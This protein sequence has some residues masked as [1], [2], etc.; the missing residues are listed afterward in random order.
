MD[1]TEVPKL[2]VGDQSHFL[3]ICGLPFAPFVPRAPGLT[4][5]KRGGLNHRNV[6]SHVLEAR[7][8]GQGVGRAELPL[9]PAGKPP[10]FCRPRFRTC[11]H[12]RSPWL[13][14]AKLQPAPVFS[15]RPPSCVCLSSPFLTGTQ[16]D[17]VKGPPYSSMTSSYLL[18]LYFQMR[19]RSQDWKSRR[20]HIFWGTQ[21]NPQ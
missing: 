11:L 16:S 2:T 6:S 20:Q 5:H 19:S 4:L 1:T 18:Q 15:R 7:V 3:Q 14:A 13:A 10:A 8:S 9:N 17:W 12:S 21:F